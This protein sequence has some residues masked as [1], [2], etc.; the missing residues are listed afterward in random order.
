[1]TVAYACYAFIRAVCLHNV[2]C[3]VL[4]VHTY[5]VC[6]KLRI[7]QCTYVHVHWR[8]RVGDIAHTQE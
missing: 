4:H 1:M 7:N 6:R 8:A 3:V 5:D 2:Y